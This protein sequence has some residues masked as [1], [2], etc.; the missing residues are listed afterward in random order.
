MSPTIL[1]NCDPNKNTDCSKKS[2]YLNGGP[3][4]KTKLIEYAKVPI[5]TAQMI[6]DTDLEDITEEKPIAFIPRN[7]QERRHGSTHKT[8]PFSKKSPKV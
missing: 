4:N 1:Y 8:I 3:C 2:C 7:R 6:L 5:D